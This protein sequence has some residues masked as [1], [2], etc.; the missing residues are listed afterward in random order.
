MVAISSA[1]HHSGLYPTR[2]LIC[3]TKTSPAIDNIFILFRTVR[4]LVI[5]LL[6]PNIYTESMLSDPIIPSGIRYERSML[7]WL[8][9]AICFR[10]SHVFSGARLRVCSD[11]PLWD[12]IWALFSFMDFETELAITIALDVWAACFIGLSKAHT[13]LRIV[14]YV[15]VLCFQFSR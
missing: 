6:S 8:V 9:A 14:L 5:S 3:M 7:K 1:W 10:Y 4:V 2:S 12:V 15:Q 11:L 13:I